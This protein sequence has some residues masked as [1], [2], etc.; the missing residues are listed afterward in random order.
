MVVFVLA[1]YGVGSEAP[2]FL[3]YLFI[4]YPGIL[5]QVLSIIVVFGIIYAFVVMILSDSL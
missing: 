2:K 3:T 5:G 1:G 4:E